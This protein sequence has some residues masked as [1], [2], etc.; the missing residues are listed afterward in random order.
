[1]YKRLHSF[2]EENNSFYPHYFGFRPNHLTNSALI[3]KAF[4]R[5]LFVCGVYLDLK[6]AF[7][8]INHSILLTKLE[9]YGIKGNANYWLRSFLIDRKQYTSVTGK[10]SNSQEITHGVPQG[11]VLGPL[12]F[13]ILIND[14][15][16]SITSNAI[17]QCSNAIFLHRAQ[18]V[19]LKR[20]GGLLFQIVY[21]HGDIILYIICNIQN[22]I[23]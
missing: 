10:D 19:Y 12:L 4:D 22:N 23:M 7:D 18:L 2:L 3:R 13:I 14:L 20:K 1:M 5:G 15:N 11:S 9:H 16:L 21:Y 17:L 8:T 6:K